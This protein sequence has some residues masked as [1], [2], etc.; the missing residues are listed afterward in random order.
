M[1]R[2]VSVVP[3]ALATTMCLLAGGCASSEERTVY[4]PATSSGTIV[5]GDQLG[6]QLMQHSGVIGRGS[7]QAR[8]AE[9]RAFTTFAQSASAPVVAAAQGGFVTMMSSYPSYGKMRDSDVRMPIVTF[10]ATDGP[11]AD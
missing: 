11:S 3:A 5:A 4:V 9:P 10:A 6:M 8:A 1:R 7:S 2:I